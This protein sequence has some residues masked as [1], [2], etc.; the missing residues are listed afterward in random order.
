MKIIYINGYKE[1]PELSSTYK[2]LKDKGFDISPCNWWY[3]NGINLDKIKGCI[4]N[5]E[6]DIIVASSTGCLIAEYLSDIPKLLINPVVDRTDLETLFNKD[7]SNLPESVI[8]NGNIR[9]VILG[10]SDEV[11]DYNKSKDIYENCFI[12]DETH[13]IKNKNI[14]E[15]HLNDLIEFLLDLSCY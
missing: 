3:D 4:K 6:P 9:S 13:R 11:L 12:Y 5:E 1:T 15:T 10:S 14:I 7:F 2:F 8:R